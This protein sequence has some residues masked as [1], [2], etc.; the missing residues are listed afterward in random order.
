MSL[1]R[2]AFL[3]TIHDVCFARFPFGST[4]PLLLNGPFV[5]FLLSGLHNRIPTHSALNVSTNFSPVSM[6]KRLLVN[7]LHF[8]VDVCLARVFLKIKISLIASRIHAY[9]IWHE[10][11]N[12]TN[13]LDG[14]LFPVVRI[15]HNLISL[16]WILYEIAPRNQIRLLNT[17]KWNIRSKG[18]DRQPHQILSTVS[19][20]DLYGL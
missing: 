12:I 17:L 7:R 5:L 8:F 9:F 15:V 3:Q 10:R 20:T 16:Y 19:S 6:S 14:I 13:I 18:P 1:S 2:L 11:S 4:F